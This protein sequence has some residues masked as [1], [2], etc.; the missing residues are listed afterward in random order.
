MLSSLA[1]GELSASRHY[2]TTYRANGHKY[3]VVLSSSTVMLLY[4]SFL[5]CK[6][7]VLGMLGFI[8]IISLFPEMV[9]FLV[10]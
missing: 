7:F 2:F 9:L 1:S 5:G 3:W 4:L 6:P 10:R 8:S